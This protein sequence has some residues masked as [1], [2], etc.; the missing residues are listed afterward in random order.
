M[1]N[2]CIYTNSHGD[3][4]ADYVDLNSCDYTLDTTEVINI[5]YLF[6]EETE[7]EVYE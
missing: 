3:L 6:N 2:N 1:F 7:L 4:V 5:N